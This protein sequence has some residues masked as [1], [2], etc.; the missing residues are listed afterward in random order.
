MKTRKQS[1]FI[2]IALMLGVSLSTGM[3]AAAQEAEEAKLETVVE[4]LYNP[5]G[6]AIQPETGHVFVADSGHGKIVRIVDG[7]AED[8]VTGFALD[9]Y[10]KGPM[11]DIGPLGLLFLDKNTIV[12]GGGSHPDGEEF[13]SVYTIPAAGEA[14]VDA[15]DA[16]T[17]LSLAA[18][19]EIKGEGNFY[20]LA[21]V[22]GAIYVTCNGDD[23]KGWVSKATVTDGKVGPYERFI[24]TKEAVEVDAPVGITI[25]PRGEIVVGQMGEITI[26][27]DS[28]LTFYDTSGKMLA[29]FETGLSDITALAYS[30]KG[31]E[32]DARQLYATDFVWSDTTQGGLFQLI[33]EEADGEMTVRT[34]KIADLDKPTAMAFAEDGTLYILVIGTDAEG[35]SKDSGKLLKVAPGL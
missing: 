35:G 25:S 24:A 3:N 17:Q 31:S 12:V 16:V 4:G 7:K 19:E 11:Y 28:L 21:M 10:G 26:P 27:G 15:K 5:C 23:T 1:W 22:D 13:L 32:P 6:L 2:A 8:V 20:Q 29:N 30:P 9:V 18:T 14:A 34:N 33:G